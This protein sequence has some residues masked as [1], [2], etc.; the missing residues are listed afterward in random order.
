MRETI[1]SA[2]VSAAFWYWRQQRRSD[3]Q[4]GVLVC[5][6]ASPGA[7]FVS[8]SRASAESFRVDLNTA[9]VAL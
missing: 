9:G 1:C 5:R 3:R 6:A 2:L 7:G 4:S 8:G